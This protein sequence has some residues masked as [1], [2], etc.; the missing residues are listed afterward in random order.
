V[1]KTIPASGHVGKDGTLDLK[2]QTGLAESDVDVLVTIRPRG[3]IDKWPEGFI[4][5]TYGC[6]ADDPIQRP[7][8]LPFEVRE[9]LH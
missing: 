6:L 1:T 5:E 9:P 8:Q 3:K 2:L 4:E 7:T